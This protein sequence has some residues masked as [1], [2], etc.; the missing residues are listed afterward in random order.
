MNVIIR[1]WNIDDLELLTKFQ[2]D[3]CN[4]DRKM[5]PSLRNDYSESEKGQSQ[6]KDFLTNDRS[7]VLFAYVDWEP[8]GFLNWYNASWIGDLKNWIWAYL[9]WVYVTE[10]YRWNWIW[11]QLIQTFENIYRDKW[12]TNIRLL[13]NLKNEKAIKLYNSLWLESI[14][15]FMEK[16]I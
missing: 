12:F 4:E 15:A 14:Y 3:F 10:K 6:Y 5:D 13:V 2:V 16:K 1:K 11:K 8:V 9:E 7:T